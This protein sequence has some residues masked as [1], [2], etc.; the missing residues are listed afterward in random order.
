M[1]ISHISEERPIAIILKKW[2]ESTFLGQ[3]SVFISS[4]SDSI[5][6]GSKW[7]DEINSALDSAKVLVILCSPA[8]IKRPW[9]NFEAGCGWI[10]RIPILPICHSGMTK[11]DLP[12]P[13]SLSQ[14]LE[15]DE[16]IFGQHLFT[17]L[18]KHF[19][20]KS[21]PQI[22]YSAFQNELST[23]LAKVSSSVKPTVGS[24]FELS[25][26]NDV[27]LLEDGDI[28]ALLNDWWPDRGDAKTHKVKVVFS[29]IDKQLNL[30][31][32][33]TRRFIG[34]VAKEHHYKCPYEGP[35]VA[36]YEYQQPPPKQRQY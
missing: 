16:H 17:S 8:S 29:D 21:V 28:L 30:P 9:I 2:I 18:A 13:L 23:A 26:A 10:K 33:S 31:A 20:V 36:T 7:L 5:P 34:R 1:F 15:I 12:L 4:D 27:G 35:V 14:G 3:R 11:S 25:T 32:G 6:A 19:K 22:D 24:T